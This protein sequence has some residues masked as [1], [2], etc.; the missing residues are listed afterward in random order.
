MLGCIA[1]I[2]SNSSYHRTI[3]LQTGLWSSS[4][5]EDTGSLL[6]GTD[7]P[8]IWSAFRGNDQEQGSILY[9]A[10]RMALQTA[11]GVISGLGTIL[12]FYPDMHDSRRSD[13]VLHLL[14]SLLLCLCLSWVSWDLTFLKIAGH[15][16]IAVAFLAKISSQEYQRVSSLS[17]VPESAH[18]LTHCVFVSCSEIACIVQICTSQGFVSPAQLYPRPAP[19]IQNM[20]NCCLAIRFSLP[21]NP[22]LRRRQPLRRRLKLDGWASGLLSRSIASNFGLAFLAQPKRTGL[23]R[24]SSEILR[25]DGKVFQDCFSLAMVI[26][27]V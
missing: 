19:R 2:L 6:S 24:V 15:L 13:W 8:L 27:E 18:S 25:L 9:E 14:V 16:S 1:T 23:L 20:V 5:S 11:M 21:R 10:Y 17:R 12:N 3:S 7:R 26:F 4:V 22:C